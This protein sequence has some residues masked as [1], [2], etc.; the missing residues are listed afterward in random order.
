M[1]P[2]DSSIPQPSRDAALNRLAAVRPRLGAVYAADRNF[3]LGPTRREG[4]SGLSPYLR[5]RL[6]LEREAVEAAALEHGPARAE[7]FIQEVFW[8]TYWKGWL[9][10]RP[11]VWRAY[12]EAVLGFGFVLELSDLNGRQRLPEVPVI[13]LVQY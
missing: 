9:E 10:R 3:D 12:R 6:L 7:K 11:A 2:P 5:H 1:T 8:R 13:S 4:V